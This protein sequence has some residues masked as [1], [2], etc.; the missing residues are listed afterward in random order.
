MLRIA[1]L[2]RAS[3][4]MSVV[5]SKEEAQRFVEKWSRSDLSERAASHEHFIDLCRLVGQPAR[6]G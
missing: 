3:Q 5:A 1:T 4:H 2:G 6:R